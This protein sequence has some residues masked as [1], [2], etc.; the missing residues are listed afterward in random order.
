MFRLKFVGLAVILLSAGCGQVNAYVQ[1]KHARAT[2]VAENYPWAVYPI[3]EESKMAICDA[4][5]LPADDDFCQPG[6]EVDH[7]DV[8]TKIRKVFPVGKTR[9]AQVEA[10][11]GQFPHTIE[12]SRQPDG[13]LVGLRY[14]YRLTEY[15]GAC[16]SFYISLDD[17]ETIDRID[18][19]G[20]GS[21]PGPTT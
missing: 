8:L 5:A 19:T 20:L 11:L 21:G 1:Q 18:A 4:L 6:T 12:E 16:V 17:L 15:E 10:K 9:Y 7:G 14:V 3:S 13:D 2:W